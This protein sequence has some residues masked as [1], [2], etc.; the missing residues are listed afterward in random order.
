MDASEYRLDTNLGF[1]LRRAQQINSALFTG[2]NA[3]A[4]SNVQ[5]AA[6]ARLVAEGPTSQNALGRRINA[7]AATIKGVVGRLEQRGAVTTERDGS[8]RRQ[9]LV[10]VTDVG[11][12]LFDDAIAGSER[13]TERMLEC[14]SP[15]E[16]L[17]LVELL[18]KIA[19]DAE[20]ARD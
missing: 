13:T 5:F 3:S 8:D 20:T 17:M 18:S 2:L 12:A 11:V 4:L 6:L 16:R 14:L 7:D 19:A 15:G 1:L 10:R 9:L